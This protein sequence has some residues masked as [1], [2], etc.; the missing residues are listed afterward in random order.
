MIEVPLPRLLNASLE[1]ERTVRPVSMSM[2]LSIVPLSY[3]SMQLP[4]GESL[5]A[6][7]YVELYNSMGFAGVFRVR[8]PQDA[9]GDDIT[10]AELEHAI[11]E[12]GDYLVL[13]EYDQMMAASTAMTTVFSHYRG[14][15]WQLG[16][17]GALGSGQ[18][19]L[20]VKYERVLEAMLAILDQKPN[21]MMSFDFSTKPWT[22][23]I[24]SRGTTVAAEGRLSRNVN[25]AKVMYDD[26]ELCTRCYYEC[27]TTEDAN[28]DGFP[29]FEAGNNYSKDALVANNNKLYKLTNGHTKGTSWANTTKT[30][31][32]GSPTSSWSYVDADTLSVYGLVERTISTGSDYTTSEA[33]TAVNAYLAKH[34]DPRVSVTISAEELSSVTG[35]P[36]DTFT[37][38]KLCRLALVDYGVT[39]ERN[40]TGLTWDNVY[41]A[42]EDVTVTLEDEED[43]AITF[44]HDL[45]AKGGAGGGGGGGGGA[46]KKQDEIWKEYRTKFE[47]TDYYFDLYAQRFN[48]NE[49]ILQQAGLYID[50]NGVLVYAQD[51]E[52]MWASKLQ[53]ESN[54]ISMVVE[55]TGNNARIKAAQIVASIN[56]G[57]S[58]IKL[59]AD[60]IDIDGL[61]EKLTALTV[62]VANLV[63]EGFADIGS[64]MEI[65][66]SLDVDQAV[67]ADAVN[68]YNVVASEFNS[69]AVSWQSQTVV[70]SI[71][72]IGSFTFKDVN[73]TNRTGRLLTS[74]STKTLHYLGGVSQ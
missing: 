12:V 65:G 39:V 74:I 6:R 22:V 25:S 9:Y 32:D 56:N 1:V 14:N 15:K 53:V 49:E 41:D 24:V 4:R 37:I 16:S 13:G 60:H 8:S 54:R 73:G 47:Q 38:G 58:T 5:P 55:G 70:N 26:T 68:A 64:N 17:V 67:T 27:S 72:Y 2:S 69:Q 57:E 40:I 50:A 31:V 3:A 59:S 43:T 29:V 23:N 18:I 48:R 33:L 52:N 7:G 19:A 71:G 62:D 30:V 20:Q 35:E 63:V 34:K 36:F 10:T 11:V 21:C 66:G 44:L 28:G 51:N 45:D 42:P 46:A 61:V